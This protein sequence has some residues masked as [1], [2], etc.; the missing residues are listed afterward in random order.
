MKMAARP[1]RSLSFMSRTTS[2]PLARSLLLAFLPFHW[3]ILRPASR[4]NTSPWLSDLYESSTCI[5]RTLRLP[6]T[7]KSFLGKTSFSTCLKPELTPP[8]RYLR[9][10]NCFQYETNCCDSL[11]WTCRCVELDNQPP[12]E[13]LGS[14]RY[15]AELDSAA[16]EGIVELDGLVG[17]GSLLILR[18]F[19]AKP[20]AKCQSVFFRISTRM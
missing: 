3:K 18:R 10:P 9:P 6:L 11:P 15:L 2:R 19:G 4:M 12:S 13:N 5:T 20:A 7:W 16:A 17:D 14:G 8:S 1:P